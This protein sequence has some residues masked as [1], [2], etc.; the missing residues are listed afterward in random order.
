MGSPSDGRT[1]GEK[2]SGGH[3]RRRNCWHESERERARAKATRFSGRGQTHCPLINESRWL[4][5]SI[6]ISSLSSSFLRIPYKSSIIPWPA[7]AAC[8]L[9]RPAPSGYILSAVGKKNY[10][11]NG[12]SVT[13]RTSTYEFC[14][15]NV[16]CAFLGALLCI[17][18]NSVRNSAGIDKSI[19]LASTL[20]G[21]Y[22]GVLLSIHRSLIY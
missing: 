13:R 21:L 7:E 8:W 17:L 5:R 20:G 4:S 18:L 12:K 16:L 11:K 22:S 9:D 14:R 3:V 6:Y 10:R 2:V 19:V 1:G 15:R